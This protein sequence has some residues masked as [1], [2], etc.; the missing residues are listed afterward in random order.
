MREVEVFTKSKSQ[1]RRALKFKVYV[2]KLIS[3]LFRHPDPA[4]V[5]S[6]GNPLLS[7]MDEVY[8]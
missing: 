1:I 5:S 7:R 2:V 4:M 8:L 3:M 6:L